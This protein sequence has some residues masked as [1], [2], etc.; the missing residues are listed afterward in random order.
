MTAAAAI[1]TRGLTK[2]FGPT[3]A[4]EN[5]NLR[6]EP[7]QIFGFLGPN[8]AG[9]T[10]TIRVLLDLHHPSSGTARVLGLDSRR[11]SV[12]I[13]RRCGY[14]PG[15]L[16]LY[17]R[18]TGKHLI[19]WFASARGGVNVPWLD[20]LVERFEVALNRPL[21]ELSKGNRQKLGI[22]LAFMHQPQLLILDEPT[23]GLDP[24]MQD[25]F[26]RLLRETTATGRTVFL[27]SHELDEVQRVADQVA[28]IRNGRLVV[29]DTVQ[30]LREQA[31][32]T[33]EARFAAP[34]PTAAFERLD[35]VQLV[36]SV[37]ERITLRVVGR[38]APVLRAI[39]DHDPI[40]VVARHA[41]LDEL[42]LSY[43]REQEPEHA[44]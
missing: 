19:D 12:A 15:E 7:G 18:I 40:D 26:H 5:L 11:D 8:G 28:I 6:I 9:K 33:I 34:I 25:Q 1:E 24:L 43:Y 13:H 31:P 38:L 14:L 4:V 21:R 35:G 23:S 42:F 37:G 27:S 20:L 41:D 29:A 17:P 39:A 3:V 36:H 2:V 10:T 32:Q 44:A 30:H 22:V 16:E